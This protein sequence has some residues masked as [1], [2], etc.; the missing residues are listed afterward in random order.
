MVAMTDDEIDP[1]EPTVV[2]ERPI[3]EREGASGGVVEA[4]AAVEGTDPVDLTTERNI[5]L[6]EHVDPEALD[7]VVLGGRG[8][9]VEIGFAVEGYQVSVT[10]ERIVVSTCGT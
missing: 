10:P 4:I 1:S 2:V 7:R 8:G 5:V 9:N 6:Y 3:D